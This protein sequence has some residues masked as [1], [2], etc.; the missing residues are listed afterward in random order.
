MRRGQIDEL[1]A[2]ATIARARSFTRAAAELNV[3]PSAL[4]H[5]MKGLEKRLGLQLLARTT[6]SVAPTPAGE[7]LLRSVESAI[8]EVE[9]GLAALGDWQSEPSGAIRLTAFAYAAQTIL[10]SELPKFLLKHPKVSVEVVV[11]G[12]LNDIVNDGFDAGI[13]FGDF[14]DKDMIAVRIGPDIR[15]VIVGS[16]AYFEHYP[17]PLTPADL[18]IHNCIN[19]RQAGSGGLMSWDFVRD[20]KEIRA[21]PEGQLVVGGGELAMATVLAEAG[22]GYVLEDHALPH[23]RTGRLLQ[24]LDDW[25]APF[26]GLHLYYPSRHVSPALRALVDALRWDVAKSTGG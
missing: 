4:S 21:R 14:V 10:S 15:T 9:T 6:R 18:D 17:R 5:T 20:G 7:I 8:K 25:C 24:V 2:F 1:L 12:R 26:P 13:R 23:L 22:L 11:D 16:P 19:Y 3:S